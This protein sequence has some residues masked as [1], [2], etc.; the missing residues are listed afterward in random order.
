MMQQ[1]N[2]INVTLLVIVFVIVGLLADF[3]PH[4]ALGSGLL[5]FAVSQLVQQR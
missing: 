1:T 3:M 5:S 2:K 4:P